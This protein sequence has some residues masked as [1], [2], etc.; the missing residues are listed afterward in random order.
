MPKTN[1][2][3]ITICLLTSFALVAGCSN[4]SEPSAQQ[5]IVVTASTGEAPVGQLG[6]SVVP[7]RYRLELKIDPTSEAFS[8]AVEIDVM[9]N[10]PRSGIWLHG[11][12]LDVKDTWLTDSQSNRVDARF[13]QRLESGVALLALTRSIQPG[14]ATL[15]F[16]YSGRFNHAANAL[17]K[18]V[19]GDESYA[20]TQ[21]EPIAARQV[22]PGFDEP[23][24]KV[25]FDLTVIAR[26]GEVAITTTPEASAEP[27]GDGFVKHVFDT[28]R[29]LP[30]YL[31]AFA[32]GPY[33]LVDY[34]MIPANSVRDR[35]I[36]LRGLTA[37]GLGGRMDYALKNTEG[38]LSV[39]E[40]YFGTPY[41]YKKLD[42]IAV[43][44]S[45]GGAME[46]PGAIT[47]DEY[48]VLMDENSSLRQRRAYTSVHAHEMA[49]MWFGD[50]V[51]PVWWND[52]WLNESFAS[53]MMNK[54]ADG[55][56]PEG[57]FDRETLKGALGAMAGDSLASAREIREPVDDNDKIGNAFDGITYQKGGGVLAMLERY[58]GEDRFQAGVRLHLARHA[59][60]TATAEDFIASLAEGSE[61]A[62]ITA[63]F[64]SYIEQPGVPLISAALN[65]DDEKNPVLEVSQ[66]RYAP[67]GSSIEPDS[68]QWHIPMCVSYLAGGDLKSSCTLFSE[69]EQ[70]IKLDV[71]SCPTRVLPNA[72]GAGYYRFSMDS[73]G[74]S[75]LISDASSLPAAEALAAADSLDAA[76]RAGEVSAETW[77]HGMAAL[78]NHDV[79][80]V[81]D[82]ATGYLEQITAIIQPDQLAAVEQ[83]FQDIVRPRF[84][85][86]GDA[87]DPGSV[88]LRQR[89]QR[90][91]IVIAKDQAMR[92]PLAKQ[93]AARI[94]LDG[95]PD[96]S[97]VEQSELETVFSVGVQD[98]GEP[99]F[100]LLLKQAIASEDPAFR[101]S[102]IGALAR[103]EDPALVS[104]LQAVLLAGKFKGTEFGRI[105]SRQ[106]FRA[107]T[108]ELTYAWVRDNDEAIFELIPQ[109][110]RTRAVAGIGS[111][112]CTAERADEWQAFVRSNAD[113]LPG[114]ER[115]L[116]QA[117]ESIQLCA[118]LREAKAAELV[119]AFENYSL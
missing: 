38:I 103:V 2:L 15:H 89:M 77:L 97:A 75:S 8:G 78:V 28:T 48:L 4:S 88:L 80:D 65:C 62:E 108:T 52:I 99:F 45:F 84:A 40:E 11:K 85:A 90:F 93:A 9:V 69:R 104:K 44:E 49:H 109:S 51:T 102:A 16:N 20:A 68:G 70:S 25:P 7:I 73:A 98:I 107:A 118:A 18:V 27:L 105:V 91:L 21:F 95:D 100:D 82:A 113:K 79:W 50:S 47:Y 87:T 24:F 111:A 32:V 34:G 106:M 112:F 110:F 86:L 35:E 14:P 119:T 92:D 42:L 56:W 83:A 36:H 61:R 26:E 17:F 33:D 74:W 30:T 117:T 41:P 115:G 94:G 114:Y 29:P 5:E 76:F 3:R 67:L 64:E 43:P 63:A 54:A 57:K 55:Y 39:L 71:D 31:L 53:W 12:N 13:E 72:D 116:A 59:D 60:S 46:N 37:K 1:I 81:A 6:N 96:P 101:G 10:E 22:F 19:R 58:V 23:G 66:R